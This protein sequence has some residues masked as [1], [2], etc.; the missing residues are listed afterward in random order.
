MQPGADLVVEEYLDLVE[1][2]C[3]HFCVEA[4]GAP[5]LLGATERLISAT[6][7]YGGSR[8]GGTVLPPAAAKL[9]QAV[10]GRARALGLIG[11]CGNR[12]RADVLRRAEGFDLNFPINASNSS[13]VGPRCDRGEPAAARGRGEGA[14]R[15]TATAARCPTSSI[16]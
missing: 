4:I 12:H 6:C 16:A 14:G 9:C 7:A 10:A 8:V 13:S 2:W 11:Y 15:R 3:V 1:N 5:R